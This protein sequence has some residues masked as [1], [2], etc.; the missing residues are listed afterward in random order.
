MLSTKNEINFD[1]IYLDFKK[2]TMD[3]ALKMT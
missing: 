3:L 2:F 1:T